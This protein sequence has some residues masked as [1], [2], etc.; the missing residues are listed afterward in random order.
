MLSHDDIVMFV[1]FF[2]TGRRGSKG[3]KSLGVSH[4][5]RLPAHFVH[6]VI[7]DRMTLWENIQTKTEKTAVAGN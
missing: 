2:E 3:F 4:G 7:Q 6:K 5:C 1:H